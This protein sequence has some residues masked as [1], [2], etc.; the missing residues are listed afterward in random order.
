MSPSESDEALQRLGSPI[1][2]YL[3][4][5]SITLSRSGICTCFRCSVLR[6]LPVICARYEFASTT[7]TRRRIVLQLDTRPDIFGLTSEWAGRGDATRGGAGAGARDVNAGHPRVVIGKT[8]WLNRSKGEAPSASLLSHQPDQLST[9]SLTTLVYLIDHYHHVCRHASLSGRPPCCGISAGSACRR[10]DSVPSKQ[11]CSRQRRNTQPQPTLL[12]HVRTYAVTPDP[13]HPTDSPQPSDVPKPEKSN[14]LWILS[15]LTAASIGAWYYLNMPGENIH[16][17][18]QKDADVAAQK[19]KELSDAG[20]RTA[21]D[22]VKEGEKEYQDLKVRRGSLRRHSVARYP[23]YTCPGR[24]QGKAAQRR[25]DRER[26]R[27]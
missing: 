4:C 20:K 24:R 22:I 6:Q 11:P 23:P 14:T 2:M 1:F 21:Q 15:G 7:K 17:K 27:Y 3:R 8:V 10:A 12:K 26:V 19:A 5:T 16:E 25:G 18:R 13:T 9:P